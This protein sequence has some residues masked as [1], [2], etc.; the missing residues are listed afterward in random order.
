MIRLSS[1]RKRRLLLASAGAFV[2]AAALAAVPPPCIP[3]AR[4]DA[5]D[6]PAS[7]QELFPYL[8]SGAYKTFAHESKAHRSQGPHGD[9]ITYVNPILEGSL[10]AEN[11]AHPAGAAA[12]KELVAKD[13]HL[14]G[15][16]VSVKTQAE[17]DEGDGWYWYEVF[18]TTDGS[19]PLADGN[20]VVLC[21]GCHA[22]GRDFVR[23]PYP[24][25]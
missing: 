8:Q 24:L 20:G 13:G 2:L 3:P 11:A 16:S 12:V 14:I 22:S 15:W 5:G 7:G 21:T 10:K 18:S 9:V 23:I 4:A 25:R 19:G 17:S 6:V 1:Q